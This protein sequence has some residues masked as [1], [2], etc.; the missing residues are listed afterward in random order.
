MFRVL[1]LMIILLVGFIG[2]PYI[3]GKQGYVR[4]LTESHSIEM[5]ITMLVI[6][7]VIALALVYGIEWVISRFFRLSS[8]TYNWFSVRKRRKAQQQILQGFVK[9]DEGNYAKAEKLIGKN[10]KHSSE[11]ILNFVKAAE[12][13]QQRG[14]EFSANKYLIEATEL[15]GSDNLIVELARTRILLQQN[16]L[17]TARTAVDSL[18]VLAPKNVEVLRLAVEIYLRSHAYLAL[19]NLLPKIGKSGLYAEAEFM[20]LQH[21]VVDGLLD[22]KMN[23]DGIDGLLKWWEDQPRSRRQNSYAIVGMIRRL[24][25][26]DDHDS[27]Y[28]LALDSFKRIES[29]EMLAFVTQIARLQV[30]NS[31]KIMKWL[32]KSAKSQTDAKLN[33][34]FARAIGY[35]SLRANEFDKARQA[36]AKILA[37]EDKADIEVQDY[38]V[39]AYLAE[40]ANDMAAAQQ[41]RQQCLKDTMKI[42]DNAELT[43]DDV[44]SLEKK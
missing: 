18:L 13:A 5:S 8:G 41:I 42:D 33:C 15:A 27:A 35:L 19:D 30:A 11:P 7:F 16:K 2:G 34:A 43:T 20:Q 9:M 23:E 14:D 21:Q 31:S 6:F 4:I 10:A 38:T 25:D 3:S 32:E 17:P 24:I 36:F 26:S 1:F 44:L 40:K 39:A 37:T 29:S 28:R 12:A 22:E